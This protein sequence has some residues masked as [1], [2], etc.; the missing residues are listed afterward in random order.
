MFLEADE[1]PRYK[2]RS[3]FQ[4]PVCRTYALKAD[5]LTT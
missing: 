1:P 2:S 5:K 4:V 3:E